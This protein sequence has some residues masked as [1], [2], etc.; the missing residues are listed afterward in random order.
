MKRLAVGLIALALLGCPPANDGGDPAPEP[1]G[2]G[3]EGGDGGTGGAPEGLPEWKAELWPKGDAWTQ[4]PQELTF[5]NGAEPETLDVHLMTGVPEGRIA[6]GLF[7]CLVE[8]H[9]Q[10]LQPV[11]GVAESWDISGDGTVYTFHIRENAKWSDG[12]KLTAQHVFASWKRAL[13]P[14][15]GCQYGYMFY[16]I[17][18]AQPFHTGELGDFA[19]VGVEATDEHTLVVTLEAPCPYFLDLVAFRT[20]APVPVWVI[21]ELKAAGK[22]DRWSRPENMVCNGPF[23]L[24]EWAPNQKIVM[25]TNPH[26]WDTDYVK[27]TQ[28]TALPYEDV[29]TAYNLFQEGTCDW[30]TT[31]P[32]AKIDEVQLLPEYFVQ[33]YLGSYF[34]RVNVTKPPFDDVRV[35]KALSIGFDRSIITRDVLK[36]GQIPATSFCPPLPG[37]TPPKGVGYDRDAAR[38]LLAEAGFPEGKGFPTVELLYNSNEDHKKVA[39][40]IV[41]QWKENLGITVSLRNSEWKVYLSDVEELNYAIARAGWIGD[42]V[43]PNTFLD[44]WLKDGGNNNTGWSNPD[45]TKLIEEAAQGG[46]PVERM[47]KFQQAESILI[48]QEFPIIPVYIYVNQGLLSPKV[49]GWYENVRDQHPFQYIWIEPVE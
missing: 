20:L 41:Q 4:V 49:Q 7:E 23:V 2:A 48:E 12:Q 16:P 27:L 14:A 21:D 3:G 42:Y 26:Y 39:E 15:T 31:V 33:P 32:S 9:P 44:M 45:Y 6:Q 30:N 40:S 38:E 25:K 10:T 29:D 36:A 43:D 34:Y 47:K 1:N 18:N 46:D 24:E 22:E 35:R 13:T 28:V 8:Q 5:N 11:P 17:K 37:Y 19:E